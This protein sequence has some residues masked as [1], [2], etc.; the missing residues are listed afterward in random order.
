[1]SGKRKFSYTP[2]S[3]VRF[4]SSVQRNRMASRIQRRWRRRRA[5]NARFSRKVQHAV[6]RSDPQ[7]YS[8]KNLLNQTAVTQAPSAYDISNIR[9]NISA[10][11]IPN[12]KWY[13]TSNKVYVNNLHL[14]IRVQASKDD[15]NTV[16]F[17]LVR[18][19][20]SEPI[21]DGMIQASQ[22]LPGVP[23]TIPELKAVDAPFL[24]INSGPD[25][26]AP[27]MD[28]NFGYVARNA[29]VDTLASMFN[30]KVVDLVWH[31]TVKVQPLYASAADPQ[32][33]F[34][35]GWPYQRVFEFNK[36]MN[37]VWTFPSAPGGTVGSDVYPT[38]NNKCYSLIVWSDSMAPNPEPPGTSHPIVDCA[39]RLS[40][41]DQD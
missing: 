21:T 40:F 17:A 13:R 34:P 14:N 23:A 35:T 39:M 11:A 19:K 29:N 27:E 38:I 37:E 4:Y 15:F 41:K 10:T 12:A 25:F 31:K 7:Q 28:L 8:I 26:G 3:R 20:R 5:S 18:H 32:V 6:R 30:P 36:K 22:T 16:C 24:P 33:A 9:Y 1:M 2:S